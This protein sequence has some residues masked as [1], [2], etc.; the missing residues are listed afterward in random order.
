MLKL[1]KGNRLEYG[2]WWIFV[3]LSISKVVVIHKTDGRKWD[4]YSIEEAVEGI[5]NAL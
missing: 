3:D 2:N 1:D 4:F 5:K